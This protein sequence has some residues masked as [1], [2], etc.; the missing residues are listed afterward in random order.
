MRRAGFLGKLRSCESEGL[1]TARR[2]LSC[3]IT[4]TFGTRRR[5]RVLSLF[6]VWDF[7]GEYGRCLPI[8]DRSCF[9][10]AG[11]RRTFAVDIVEISNF[12]ECYR[13]VHSRR[14][15]KR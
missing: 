13:Q 14:R 1:E 12:N 10:Q 4:E 9:E 5:A 3:Y 7:D 2:K 6:A 8:Q 15:Q 11:K